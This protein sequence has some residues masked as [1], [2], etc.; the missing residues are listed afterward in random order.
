MEANWRSLSEDQ[1]AELEDVARPSGWRI[2]PSKELPS[3]FPPSLRAKIDSAVVVS[4]PTSSGGTYLVYSANRVDRKAAQID[5]QPFGLIVHSSGPGSSG[6]FLQHGNWDGRSES[7]P[8][9]FWEGVD[10]SG[11][12]DYFL[13][14]PPQGLR[15]GT[16]DQLTKGHRGAFDAIVGEIRAQVDGR[17]K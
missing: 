5:I 8:S 1:Q 15:E 14:N 3:L 7:P 6:V 9:G 2:V 10:S 4:A 12:G 16:L 11:I 17:K 13:A